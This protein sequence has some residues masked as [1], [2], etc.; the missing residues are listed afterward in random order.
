MKK[1]ILI[2]VFGAMGAAMAADKPEH[3]K[4]ID[5][6]ASVLQDILKGDD[7]S[8]PEDLLQ[9]AFC[10]GVVPDMKRAGF[11]VG[12]KYG[13]GVLTC[14]TTAAGGWS[15]PSTIRI[16]GGNIGF[17]I[18][19]GETD[20]VFVVMNQK[21]L[22][23]IMKSKFTVGADGAA[24]AG[25]VGRAATAQTDAMMKAEILSYSRSRGVFAGITL[26]GATLRPDDDDNTK[27]YGHSVSHADLL[28]GKVKPTADA[29]P[30]FAVLNQHA[31]KKTN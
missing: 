16:E 30:L 15:A 12:G 31:P 17:Q 21:G 27:I 18:G 19:A 28:N 24:M 7:Q 20:M 25:P 9:K 11:I 5:E 23:G 8:I 14:R 1:L 10:V 6:S 13:K 26:D 22:D 3:A 2:S 29:Q 4:R